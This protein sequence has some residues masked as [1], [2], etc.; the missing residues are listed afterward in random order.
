MFG[1]FKRKPKVPPHLASDEEPQPFVWMHPVRHR[2]SPPVV[3]P[4]ESEAFHGWRVKPNP[5]LG[6]ERNTYFLNANA[7]EFSFA[8]P[9]PITTRVFLDTLG[10]ET[11]HKPEHWTQ[12]DPRDV[13]LYDPDEVREAFSDHERYLLSD[14]RDS[15]AEQL[16][17]IRNHGV[18]LAAASE[19]AEYL[20]LSEDRHPMLNRDNCVMLK[21]ESQD[22]GTSTGTVRVNPRQLHQDRIAYSFGLILNKHDAQILS[23]HFGQSC[24]YYA[25]VEIMI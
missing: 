15:N 19:D 13:F 5:E 20:R 7:P 9:R 3:W 11:L 4:L 8:T 2:S 6:L 18:K 17:V 22:E 21:P 12:I 25:Q 23:G 1:L 24:K 14:L 10:T 16:K